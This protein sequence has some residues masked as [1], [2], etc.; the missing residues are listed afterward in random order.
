MSAC[1]KLKVIVCDDESKMCSAVKEI[2]DP[3]RPEVAALGVTAEF[4]VRLAATGEELLAMMDADPADLVLL[5]Y[6]LPGISGMDIL[7]RFSEEKRDVS[8]IIMTA[9]ANIETAIQATRLGAFD[10]LAKPYTPEELRYTV[11]KT[12]HHIVVSRHARKL[13]AE[14]RQ[15]RF[16]FI[17][18]L[19][20]ELKAPINAFD[21]YLDVMRTMT[22]GKSMEAYTDII[23]KCSDRTDGMRKLIADLLDLTRIE[24]GQMKRQP[25]R[26]ELDKA[27]AA[28]AEGVAAE[29]A[30]RGIKL[31]LAGAGLAVE[32]DP[33]ELEI[34]LSNLFTNAV[35]YNKD[36][37]AVRA[38]GSE[39]GGKVHIC[40]EDTGIGLQQKD[41]A[42][43]FNE[44]VRIKTSA[45]VHIPGSG[46]GLAIARKLALQAGGDITVA[47]EPG[48]GS[49][50]TLSLPSAAPAAAIDLSAA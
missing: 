33:S 8:V 2:L 23:A 50:F 16:Q 22:L 21:A 48:K 25:A 41:A 40:V 7:R 19:A 43:L 12:A 46:L 37:G 35:K 3:F 6:K 4:E 47:S 39:A 44:F 17:S 13:A 5:D 36:G 26:L 32:A 10:F 30:R 20:H 24:S 18:V 29:A 42:R 14:K 9:Y 49:R 45:T 1:E 34:I 27:L 38:L 31:E 11:K 28:A 15:I